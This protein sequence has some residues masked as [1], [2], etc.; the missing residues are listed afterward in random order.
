MTPDNEIV[1][2]YK[3]PLL[4]GNPVSQGDTLEINNNLTFRVTRIPSNDPVFDGRDLEPM[5]WLE[6]NPDTVFCATI[7]PVEMV[8]DDHKLSIHPNPANDVLTNEWEGA[9]YVNL[10]IFDAL[11]R[12][13]T[14]Y[15]VSG[16][17]KYLDISSWESGIYYINI[18]G[19]E[20]ERLVVV[21]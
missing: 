16:G 14:D 13:M 18:N 5:G 12:K 8:M 15:Q 20:V 21:R 19:V 4:A 3:T 7:L 10:M 9:S 11:G 6:L 2:E 1:W 17:R